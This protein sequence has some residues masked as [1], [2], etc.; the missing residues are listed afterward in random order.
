VITLR[1]TRSIN[2][3]GLD[4]DIFVSEKEKIDNKRDFCEAYRTTNNID[5]NTQ[6]ERS[7]IDFII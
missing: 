7:V 1:S 6:T 3:V 5:V 4:E 2:I